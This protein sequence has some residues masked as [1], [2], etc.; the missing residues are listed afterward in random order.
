LAWTP[1]RPLLLPGAS[2]EKPVSWAWA[3]QARS[4]WNLSALRKRLRRVRKNKHAIV[5]RYPAMVVVVHSVKKRVTRVF[6]EKMVDMLMPI[7]DDGDA[8]DCEA[9]APWLIDPISM[10]VSIESI[11]VLLS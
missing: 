2:E 7:P 9:A 8:D 1:R 5:A 11:Y 6:V 3:S 4:V 10:P